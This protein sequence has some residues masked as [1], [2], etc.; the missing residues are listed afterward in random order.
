MRIEEHQPS[1]A[2]LK[3]RCQ[4]LG[5]EVFWADNE[6]HHGELMWRFQQSGASR[7]EA[8]VMATM[9]SGYWPGWLVVEDAKLSQELTGHCEEVANLPNF[10]TT[11]F[12]GY[13]EDDWPAYDA[14]NWRR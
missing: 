10:G 8:A 11:L 2:E 13:F 3:L 4:E 5:P 6:T 1:F 12:G 14:G 7:W 9:Q